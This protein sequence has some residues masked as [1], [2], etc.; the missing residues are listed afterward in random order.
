MKQ[1]GVLAIQPRFSIRA[2]VLVIQVRLLVEQ[3]KLLQSKSSLHTNAK[4][5]IKIEN[6]ID[7]NK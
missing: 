5:E 7:T 4:V 1:A 2:R 6:L 3:S